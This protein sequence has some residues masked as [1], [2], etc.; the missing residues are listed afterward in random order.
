MILHRKLP[1]EN[2]H[3]HGT[4]KVVE[5]GSQ[6]YDWTTAHLHVGLWH[7]LID[8]QIGMQSFELMTLDDARLFVI[9]YRLFVIV[10][11][12]THGFHAVD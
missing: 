5:F 1:A 7:A 3:G 4:V 10:Y 12:Y 8:K 11:M 9:V 2:T 6:A